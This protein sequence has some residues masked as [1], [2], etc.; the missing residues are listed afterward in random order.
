MGGAWF[1]V[2]PGVWCGERRWIPAFAGMTVGGK[3]ER[4]PAAK[5]CGFLIS[6]K[7]RRELLDIT[8]MGVK[9]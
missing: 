7:W 2:A 6:Q 8:E 3:A 9:I 1:G 5:P 4:F